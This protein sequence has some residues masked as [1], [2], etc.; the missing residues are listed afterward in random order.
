MRSS[1]ST[2]A[3]SPCTGEAPKPGTAIRP[4]VIAAAA[5]RYEAD[6]ASGSMGT[7]AAR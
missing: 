5:H 7:S 1:T 3:A 2:K 4:P 6:D